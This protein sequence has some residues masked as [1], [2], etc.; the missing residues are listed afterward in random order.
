MPLAIYHY[1][2]SNYSILYAV[3]HYLRSLVLVGSNY[4]SA[5]LWY[6]L[7]SIYALAFVIVMFKRER[8]LTEIVIVGFCI[9]CF[10]IAC[11]TLV[12]IQEQLPKILK[13]AAGLIHATIRNGRIFSGFFYLP[14]GMLFAHANASKLTG[15]I[16]MVIGCCVGAVTEIPIY[17]LAVL[18]ASVGIFILAAQT[19]LKPSPAYYW[20]RKSSTFIYFAHMYIW[21]CY[22]GIRYGTMEY[23][24]EPFAVVSSISILLGFAYALVC[25]RRRWRKKTSAKEGTG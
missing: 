18:A 13:E 24:I 7:S 22:C 19:K 14:L 5:I 20:L 23:G 17:S 1:V 25:A 6:L 4:N 2:D 15:I 8:K 21:T 10:G 12:E 16:L 11:S 9:F 3:A